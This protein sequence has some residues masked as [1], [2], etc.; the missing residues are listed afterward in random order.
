MSPTE[1]SKAADISKPYAWQLLRDPPLRTPSLPMAL[2]IYDR[3][4][5][6]FGP[7]AGLTKREIDAA[8]K[9]AA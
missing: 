3:T 8:R 7:L 2:H 1:L 4:G 9:M 6:Q 5:L